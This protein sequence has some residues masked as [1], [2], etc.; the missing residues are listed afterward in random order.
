[1]KPVWVFVHHPV[2]GPGLLAE[3]FAQHQI[4]Y[5]LIPIWEGIS[6]PR[7]LD[8]TSGLVFMGGPMSVHDPLPWVA[9]EVDLI[10]RA[11]AQSMPVLGHCLGA[12]LITLALGGKVFTGT[13]KEIGWLSIDIT[14]N[15]SAQAFFGNTST[16]EVFHWHGEQCSLP[17][18]AT[19]LASTSI[20][21]NQ[22]YLHGNTLALQFHLEVNE[23]MVQHWCEVHA[24][25]LNHA[26]IDSENRDTVQTAAAMQRRSTL[27]VN[28]LQDALH[29]TYKT[30]ATRLI[31]ESTT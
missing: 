20:T 8:G 12:Q 23:A 2:E 4:P 21:E 24:D 19:R 15:T 5:Q 11:H 10:Q 17:N 29:L 31:Q 9:P 7:N 18:N 30:W 16:L 28:T 13:T 1:M 26:L 3:F 6:V 25:E 27:A 22:A 14:P